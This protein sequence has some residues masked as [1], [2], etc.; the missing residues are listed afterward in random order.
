MPLHPKET[1][2]LPTPDSPGEISELRNLITRHGRPV[3]YAIMT[4]Y[5]RIT[6]GANNQPEL[7]ANTLYFIPL[8][9]EWLRQTCRDIIHARSP[10]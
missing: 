3:D 4:G 8:E 5:R 10:F 2:V 6:N 7:E 1:L 9:T